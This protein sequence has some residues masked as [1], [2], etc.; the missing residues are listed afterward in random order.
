MTTING[1][2]PAAAATAPDRGSP[3][4]GKGIQNMETNITS[5]A[6]A[7]ASIED[8]VANHIGALADHYR[9]FHLSDWGLV[10][11]DA[12]GKALGA[13]NDTL[14]ALC[15]ARPY[16]RDQAELRRAYLTAVL[17]EAVDGCAALSKSVFHWLLRTE[18]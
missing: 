16:D 9:L 3:I 6:N 15:A 14:I 5:A 18:H 12:P 2:G 11:D 10:S 1:N 13:I 8:L 4:P 7:P 17:P